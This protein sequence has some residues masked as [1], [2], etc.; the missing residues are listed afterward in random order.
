MEIFQ[1]FLVT[2]PYFPG[3]DRDFPRHGFYSSLASLMAVN[4]WVLTLSFILSPCIY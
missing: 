3:A 2:L 4:V 1:I